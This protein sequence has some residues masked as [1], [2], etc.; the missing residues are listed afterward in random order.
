MSAP[1]PATEAPWTAGLHSARALFRP[2]LILQ[3]AALALVL[4]YY[5]LPAARGA[6]VQLAIWRTEGGFI[7]SAFA[8]AVCGGLLPLLY[9]QFSASGP[10][11]NPWREGLFL[12]GFWAWKGAEV[13]LMYRTLNRFVGSDAGFATISFKVLIDQ[14]CFNPLYASPVGCLIFAWK[15]AGYR[16]RP[17][18]ADVKAGRWY[19]RRVLPVLIGVWALWLPVVSCVYAL[20]DPLQIPLFNV[21]LCFW[22]LLF[23]A[24]L[25][26]QQMGKP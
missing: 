10:M 17:V 9:L 26:R 13:D 8:S 7:F 19:F 14:F 25:Q 11:A 4:G 1:T 21:V 24:V 15:N 5:F 2:A 23:T 18:V 6:F 3:G 20:P 12:I 22:S 16:W